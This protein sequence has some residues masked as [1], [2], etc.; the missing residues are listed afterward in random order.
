MRRD[1]L[2]EVPH[3]V[4]FPRRTRGLVLLSVIVM[5]ILLALFCGRKREG[6]VSVFRDLPGCGDAL[7]AVS[8]ATI[9][10][11]YNPVDGALHATT[12]ST[13]GT[14]FEVCNHLGLY[15][16]QY[17]RGFPSERLARGDINFTP[18][19]ERVWYGCGKLRAE[20]RALVELFFDPPSEMNVRSK[21]RMYL[22]V[23]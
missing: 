16:I 21:G 15:I 9:S 4:W 3:H 23:R 10:Y 8:D 7:P 22:Y 6:R 11:S 13:T 5:S 20:G 19:G 14:F 12:L 1:L 18:Q 2:S 17:E